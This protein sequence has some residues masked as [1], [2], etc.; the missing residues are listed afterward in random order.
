MTIP[1]YVN[2]VH[3]VYLVHEVISLLPVLSEKHIEIIFSV[4][5]D[6]KF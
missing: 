6:K 2:Y 4:L 3:S 1:H 5:S